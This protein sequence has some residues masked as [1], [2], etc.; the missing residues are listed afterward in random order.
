MP[1]DEARMHSS[2][3]QALPGNAILG[4]SASRTLHCHALPHRSRGG[5]SHV[6][7]SQAEPGNKNSVAG[8]IRAR[9]SLG[10]PDHSR[11]DPRDGFFNAAEIAVI[12]SRRGRLQQLAEEGDK[13][14]RQAL[15]LARDPGRFLPTVSVGITLIG[16]FT[17]TFGGAS[18]VHELADVLRDAPVCR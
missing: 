10:N 16:T 9:L 13:R 2:R 5:A 17:A 15:D 3:S 12:A 4:G 6:V 8:D 1:N 18:L 11:P 7:S 14:A